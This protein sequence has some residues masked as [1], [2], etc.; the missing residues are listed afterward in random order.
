M[1][2][3]KYLHK[4][5]A[6]LLA[7]S[8]K[9]REVIK[10]SGDALFLS[11]KA[12]FAFQRDDLKEAGDLLQKALGILKVLS[13]SFQKDTRL[14]GEGAYRAALEEYVEA[15]LFASFVSKKTIGKIEGVGVEP[16]TYIGGLA[17]TVGE[18]Y[19]Y[20][21]K[22]ATEKNFEEVMRCFK[23]AASI[24]EEML[25]MNLTGYNRQKFDQAKQAMQKME[26]VRYEVSLRK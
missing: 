7:Y 19:R 3:K 18:I 5:R 17:D 20:A 12:I 8:E 1:I 23:V 26:F 6:E 22:S 2:D 25:D 9:R 13:K 16:D 14:A 10:T 4:V 21:L 11:K 24:V 15:C